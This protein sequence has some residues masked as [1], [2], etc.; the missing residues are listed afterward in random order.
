M[1]QVVN[2]YGIHWDD[3]NIAWLEQG[4]AGV[5]ALGY[6]KKS[7]FQVMLSGSGKHCNHQI[8]TAIPIPNDAHWNYFLNLLESDPL[9]ELML[10]LPKDEQEY[11]FHAPKNPGV[12]GFYITST[13]HNLITILHCL[14]RMTSPIYSQVRPIWTVELKK[15]LFELENTNIQPFVYYGLEA[16]DSKTLG[17]IAQSLSGRPAKAF[18]VGNSDVIVPQIVERI[19]TRLFTDEFNFNDIIRLPWESI[20]AVVVRKH[21]RGEWN[22]EKF[23]TSSTKKP[24]GSYGKTTTAVREARV[25][26]P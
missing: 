20:G 17:K 11:I 22:R 7:P 12:G 16:K 13:D 26:R 9:V 19:E 15:I 23:L 14:T 6:A 21:M 1:T 25:R 24:E 18:F 5:N 3:N 4:R 2:H 10:P 8:P